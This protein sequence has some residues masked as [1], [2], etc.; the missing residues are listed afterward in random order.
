MRFCNCTL[1]YFYY[2]NLPCSAV[3]IFAPFKIVPF[4]IYYLYFVNQFILFRTR[5]DLDH[6]KCKRYV[7]SVNDVMTAISSMI[8]PFKT[9]QE[10]LLSLASGVMVEND[11]AEEI[12]EQ[13]FLDF[14]KKHLLGE[15][16]D[17][18]T[19][20]KRNKLQT[21]SSTKSVSVKNKEGKK[22]NIMF[23]RNLFARL[24][25]I[26]KSCQVDLK[27]LL[28]YSLGTFPLWQSTTTGGFEK[29]AKSKLAEILENEA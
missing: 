4:M 18:F 6:T 11:V 1:L 29:T 17:I 12:G 28:S 14:F 22:V 15:N 21:F 2:S 26:A 25:V 23:N 20:L 24:L 27:E 16:P 7:K 5:K 9:E 13:Q 8:N 10:E 3:S 19:K